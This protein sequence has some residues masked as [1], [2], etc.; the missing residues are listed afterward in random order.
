MYRDAYGVLQLAY[1]VDKTQMITFRA[2]IFQKCATPLFASMPLCSIEQENIHL[3][4][5]LANT[6]DLRYYH[7]GL[8]LGFDGGPRTEATALT[9]S[10][11][12]AVLFSPGFCMQGLCGHSQQGLLPC[13]HQDVKALLAKRYFQ[14]N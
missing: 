6:V 1:A 10:D 14:H 3:Q 8:L 7:Q 11:D 4:K 2:N 5:L 9:V 12:S 13:L